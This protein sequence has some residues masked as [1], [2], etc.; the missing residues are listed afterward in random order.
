MGAEQ[1][2]NIGLQKIREAKEDIEKL[3]KGL[4]KEEEKLKVKREEVDVLIQELNKQKAAAQ[5]RGDEV[6]ADETR[7]EGE[8]AIIDNRRLIAKPRLTKPCQLFSRL[9]KLLP[10][11]L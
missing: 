7:I 11:S 3:E 4:K 10:R 6:G 1:K 9:N 8:A 5:K 2:F